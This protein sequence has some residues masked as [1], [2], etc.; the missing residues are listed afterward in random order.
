MLP[1]P[2]VA[3][4]RAVSGRAQRRRIAEAMQRLAAR[5]ATSAS[6]MSTTFRRCSNGNSAP[7]RLQRAV[8]DQ[9]RRTGTAL[10]P[11]SGAEG[12]RRAGHQPDRLRRNRCHPRK[13]LQGRPGPCG[14]HGGER[15]WFWKTVL[16]DHRCDSELRQ[17]PCGSHQLGESCL[18][19]RK[20]GRLADRPIEPIALPSCR[21]I[22]GPPRNQPRM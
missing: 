12:R 14:R 10:V 22:V 21:I 1:L 7:Q 16:T 5:P 6:H 3:P 18:P 4:Q 13:L 19:G 9:A 15:A 17:A 8:A 20:E 2:S 11:T